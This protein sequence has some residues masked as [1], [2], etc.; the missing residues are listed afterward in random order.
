LNL[1]RDWRGNPA[2]AAAAG[3]RPDADAM[4]ERA[5]EYAKTTPDFARASWGDAAVPR[6]NGLIA[7][8]RGAFA[9]PATHAANL[10]RP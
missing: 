2:T 9:V 4:L 1:T 7:D 8:T 10:A 6:C 5:R 3:G